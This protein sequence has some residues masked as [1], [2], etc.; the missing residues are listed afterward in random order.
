MKN[1]ILAVASIGGH[2]VQLLRIAKGLEDNCEVVYMSTHEKCATMVEGHR[3]YKLQDFSRW[4]A[5][6]LFPAFFNAIKFVWKEKP[7]VVITTGAAPGLVVLFAAK[8]CGKRTIW[9]DSIA[10]VNHLSLCGRIASHFASRI[11]TQWKE[12]GNEKILSTG[13]VLG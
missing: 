10:N 11:Y 3:F 2:W 12:L 8:C 7:D 4:D 13:N 9:V 5:Y 6:K 1:K